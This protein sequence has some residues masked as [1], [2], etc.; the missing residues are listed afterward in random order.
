MIKLRLKD[1][2]INIK[3]MYGQKILIDEL[4]CVLK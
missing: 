2:N 4:V 1:E 3:I